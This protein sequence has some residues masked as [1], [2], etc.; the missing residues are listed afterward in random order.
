MDN[1]V[2][3]TIVHSLSSFVATLPSLK[4]RLD[5]LA[6]GSHI[7]LAAGV[8]ARADPQLA[9][10]VA[11]PR[12]L[13]ALDHLLGEMGWDDDHAGRRTKHDIA[14]QHGHAANANGNVDAG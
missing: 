8:C 1:D 12:V 6:P 3:G 5:I 14:R 10:L 13:A 11:H 7:D 4:I 2:T 9:E